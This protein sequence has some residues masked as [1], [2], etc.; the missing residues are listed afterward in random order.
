MLAGVSVGAADLPV[1]DVLA[2]FVPGLTSGLDET[3]LT[4]LLRIRLPRVVLGGVV[5]ST[6]A[7]A[8][9]AYQGVFRNPLADPY[10]LGVAAGAGLGR[11]RGHRAGCAPARA[12]RACRCSRS[13]G[14][15][16]RS[17]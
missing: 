6:L 4:I 11:D 5:G 13:S 9:G 1:G 14:Q 15:S 2:T 7:V 16:W 12:R 10:L 17:R 8:G 3:Q